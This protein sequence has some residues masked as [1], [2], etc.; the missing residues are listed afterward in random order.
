MKTDNFCVKLGLSAVLLISFLGC[1]VLASDYEANIEKSFSVTPGGK[2]VVVAP[3]E[4][5]EAKPQ[6]PMGAYDKR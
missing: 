3:K 2:L 6:L 4:A 5:S 1:P